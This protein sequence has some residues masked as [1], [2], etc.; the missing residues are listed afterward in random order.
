LSL[1]H[2]FPYIGAHPAIPCLASCT[3][4]T[5]L[6]LQ[7]CSLLH[8]FSTQV[9][10]Q[11]ELQHCCRCQRQCMTTPPPTSAAAAAA[12]S[13]AAAA[14]FVTIGGHPA[15]ACL[16]AWTLQHCCCCQ[17][18]SMTTLPPTSAA[19][20]AAS[21][22]LFVTIGGHPVRACLVPWTLQHCCCCQR[23]PTPAAAAAAAAAA[24]F[25]PHRWTPSQ[26]LPTPLDPSALLPLSAP[27]R[28]WH[29]PSLAVAADTS[30]VAQLD[31]EMV[32]GGAWSG[33]AVWAELQLSGEIT[34]STAGEML[35]P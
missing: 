13:A 20:A 31:V 27:V 1:L 8:S 10:T 5:L 24:L 19:A 34:Y 18:T 29:L 9:G 33:V 12:A 6:L 14:L 26:S 25:S 35:L 22:A 28:V 3:L 15:R 30:A 32:Q 17:H 16:V 23:H 21:A 2:A 4:S 11:P 7:A